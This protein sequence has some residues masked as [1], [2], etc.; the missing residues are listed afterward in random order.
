VATLGWDYS[1]GSQGLNSAPAEKTEWLGSI[2]D[3]ASEQRIEMKNPIQPLAPDKSG[4]EL[5]S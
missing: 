2:N 4:C 1:A 5:R 3:D